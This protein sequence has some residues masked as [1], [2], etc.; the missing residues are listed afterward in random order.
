MK[1]GPKAKAFRV[2][3]RKVVWPDGK[4]SYCEK[5]SMRKVCELFQQAYDLG[6]AYEFHLMCER[7]KKV[8][9]EYGL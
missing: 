6:R 9:D 4:E 1:R 8:C 2:K 3:G 5:S 7:Q